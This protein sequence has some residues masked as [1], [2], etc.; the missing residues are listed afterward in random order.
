MGVCH[1][2]VA[3]SIQH[4]SM[5]VCTAGGALSQHQQ[6]REPPNTQV[7]LSVLSFRVYTQHLHAA[8]AVRALWHILLQHHTQVFRLNPNCLFAVPPFAELPPTHHLLPAAQ[9]RGGV[10]RVIFD[11]PGQQSHPVSSRRHRCQPD[12]ALRRPP[13]SLSVPHCCCRRRQQQP[14]G[15]RPPPVTR[16]PKG[17]P[18]D[19]C[20]GACGGFGLAGVH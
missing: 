15:R 11:R 9:P 1:E 4:V 8:A 13:A 19:A 7:L 17:S 2:C 3:A 12:A 16:Q 6:H 5:C 10:T 20:G 18:G 14:T